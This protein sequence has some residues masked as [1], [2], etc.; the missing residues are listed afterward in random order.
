MPDDADN[1]ESLISAAS[2]AVEASPNS[3]ATGKPA[4]TGTAQVG[5]TLA[6]DTRDIADGD[7][8]VNATFAC[9]W[10][11]YDGTEKG[12]I[13]RLRRFDASGSASPRVPWHGADGP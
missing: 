12:S 7:G 5:E 11:R 4:V 2:D 13:P 6:A 1:E 3:S 9:Q 10:V 8:L